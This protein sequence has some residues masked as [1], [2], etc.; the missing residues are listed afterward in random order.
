MLHLFS[1]FG[2]RTTVLDCHQKPKQVCSVE[3]F[4]LAMTYFPVRLD[5]DFN[6]LYVINI[7]LTAGNFNDTF[8]SV[9]VVNKN[10]GNSLHKQLLGIS[11]YLHKY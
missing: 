5:A 11:F 9:R 3:R 6:H 8:A 7:I 1:S 10:I 2:D 4:I